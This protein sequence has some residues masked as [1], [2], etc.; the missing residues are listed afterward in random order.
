M[1]RNTHGGNKSKGMARKDFAPTATHATR[2]PNG[3]F[4]QVA[5]V[6]KMLGNGMFYAD[7]IDATGKNT[8]RN[9]EGVRG[10]SV[11]RSSNEFATTLLVHIRNKFRGRSRRNNDVSVGKLVLIGL[12]DW[13]APHFKQADLLL[14]YDDHD[15]SSFTLPTSSDLLFSNSIIHDHTDLDIHNSHN[16]HLNHNTDIDDI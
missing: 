8:G 11:E 3:P 15:S 4:E 10:N 12:R 7:F 1:V 9:A 13:E 6:S 5:V 16:Y 14:V 2:M